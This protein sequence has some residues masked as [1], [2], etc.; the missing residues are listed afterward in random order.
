MT[1]TGVSIASGSRSQR[2]VLATVLG[3]LALY[4][5]KSSL[6]TELAYFQ[7]GLWTLTLVGLFLIHLRRTLQRAR[8][9]TLALI[10]FGFHCYAL[11][12]YRNSFPFHSS[13]TV[14]LAACVETAVFGLVYIRLCQAIDPSGPFGMTESEK[15]ARKKT[16]VQLG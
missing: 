15:Q 9:A 1:T 13:L 7:Q 14:V 8:A 4:C 10:L 6:G 5:E 2:M 3:I 11:Y 16:F 12:R